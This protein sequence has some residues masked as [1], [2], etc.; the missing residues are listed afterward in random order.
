MT[1]Y[2]NTAGPCSADIHYML[3]PDRRLKGVRA[4]I[5]KRLYFVL[6][7]PRQIGKT[8]SVL[9]LARALTD[10]GRFAAVLVSMETGAAFPRDI[11]AAELAILD[12][13]RSSAE[14]RLP[15]ALQPPPWPDAAPGSRIRSALSAWARASTLVVLP[16]CRGAWRTK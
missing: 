11:G 6:H 7:A 10:E 12:A 2:F 15:E 5:D 8:T 16:I 14:A 9:A 1:R 3:P 4:L 13:W